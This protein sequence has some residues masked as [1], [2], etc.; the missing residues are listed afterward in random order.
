ML[1]SLTRN[2]SIFA[3]RSTKVNLN[4]PINNERYGLHFMKVKNSFATKKKK[5]IELNP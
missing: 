5:V 3:K 4:H 2:V 1:F